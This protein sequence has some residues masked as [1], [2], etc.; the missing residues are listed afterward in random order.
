MSRKKKFKIKKLIF[1]AMGALFLLFLLTGSAVAFWVATLNIPDPESLGELKVIQS[2]KIYDRTGKIALWDIHED[3]QRTVVPMEEISRHVKNATVAIEDSSFYQHKGIDI[4]GI[5]RAILVNLR[6]ADKTQGASTISQQLVKNTLLTKEKTFARKIKEAI[7]TLKIEK[8]LSKDEILE[9][10]LNEIP[11]GGSIYGIEAAS[12]NFFGKS[13]GD[14]TLAEAAYLASLPQAPTYYSPYGNH[15]DKLEARKNL[16]LSEMVELGFIAPEEAEEAKKEK[17]NFLLKG[18]NTVKA[19]HFSIYIRSYLEEKYGKDI[20]EQG[21]LKVITTIDYPLQEKAEEMAARYAKENKEKFNASNTAI[22]AIDPKTGQILVMVGSKDYFNREDEGNFN[23][24]LAKNRQP[25]SAIKPFV[26]AAALKKGYTPE[27]TLFDLPTEFNPTCVYNYSTSTPPAS[28]EQ[29]DKDDCYMPV[30]YDNNYRGPV[31]LR[32]ALAQSLN[33]PSVKTLYLAGMRDSIELIKDMGI[34]SLNDPNR[35]GLTLVL[36]GGEVSLF[37]L[38]GAYSVFANEGKKNEITGIIRIEDKNGNILEEYHE[39]PKQVLDKNIALTISDMLSDNNAR[40][41]AFGANSPLYFPDRQVA[42]KTGTTNDYRDAWVVGYT[43]NIVA[44]AWFGNNNYDSMEKKVA[45]LIVAPMWNEFMNE[46][47]KNLPKEEFEKPQKAKEKANKPVLKGDWRGGQT[48]FIDKISG[49]LATDR[50]PP[51]LREEKTLFEVHSI[52]HWLDKNNPLGD[53]PQDPKRDSQYEMWETP[54]RRWA[55]QNNYKDQTAEDIPKEMDD[56]HKPEYAP[57][58][59]IES[60]EKDKKYS[61]DED[62]TIKFS[63]K[64]NKFPLGQADIFFNGNYLGSLSGEPY[65]FSFKPADYRDILEERSEIRIIAYD[66]VRNK[67]ETTVF[68]EFD[69]Q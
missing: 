45:G 16:V 23:V 38:T 9:L 26:Y 63:A 34:T 66:S 13:S 8:K 5:I 54:V 50:T 56:V 12:K 7:L 41:P 44:G 62:I 35:Y 27:T 69:T 17:V 58:L 51:E 30:N 29:K 3:V 65:M 47:F 11:Y 32:S 33:V 24:A 67:S 21:G 64:E 1:W 55:E 6:T 48:Y 20:V 46:A 36:G 10:Y 68:I 61:P 43:P 31:T 2:T 39:D 4:S 18:Q 19:P 15:P 60:P 52:L 40:T 14:L 49:K 28:E 22:V 59:K 37:E 57:K 25:G 42:A 53:R